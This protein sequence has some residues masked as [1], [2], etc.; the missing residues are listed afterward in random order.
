MVLEFETDDVNEQIVIVQGQVVKQILDTEEVLQLPASSSFPVVIEQVQGLRGEKGEIG[1][2]N[3]LTI[4]SVTASAPG[5]P[6]EATITGESPS[7]T[8]NFVI[9][10]GNTGPATSLSVAAVNTLYSG[11]NPTVEVGGT[12]PT[13]TLT[14]GIPKGAEILSGTDAPATE[15]GSINDWYINT[16]TWDMY[17]KTGAAVWT[18][19]MNIRGATGPANNLTIGTVTSA[20]SNVTPAVTVTGTSPN[21]ALNFTIPKGAQI[22]QGTDTPANG[23]GSVGDWFINT[24]NWDVFEKT[25]AAVWTNRGNIKG[26]TG[27][28]GATGPTG[29]ANQLSIGTVTTGAPGSTA[30]ANITGTA[31]VQTLSL[32]IPRGDVGATGPAPNLA[33]GTVTTGA[34]GSS[35]A[36]TVTGTNP[37]YLI[38]LTVPR[39]D[40]GEIG[41]QWYSGANAPTSGQYAVGDYY[42]V[43]GIS[44]TGDVYKKTDATTWTLEGNIRGLPG[45]GNVNS[46]NGILPDGNGQIL[47][48]SHVIRPAG[49]SDSGNDTTTGYW[50]RIATITLDAQYQD[51][52]I[53]VSINSSETGAD[54]NQGGFVAMNVRQ[55]DPLGTAPAVRFDTYE[56]RDMTPADL[57]YTVDST[58][59]ESAVTFWIKSNRPYTKFTYFM[60][61]QSNSVGLEALDFNQG[62]PRVA[63]EPVG[64]TANGV[65]NWHVFQ[66]EQL[67]A[68]AIND[69]FVVN[70][71]AEMLALTAQVGDTAVRQDT[72]TTYILK[73]EPATVL[74]NWIPLV[75]NA[76]NLTQGTVPDAVLPGRLQEQPLLITD[77][78]EAEESGFYQ[79]YSTAANTPD[80]ATYIGYS[81]PHGGNYTTQTVWRASN[82][83]IV[84]QRI[85]LSGVWGAWYRLQWSQASQDAR[86]VQLTGNQTIAGTKT[87]SNYIIAGN[88]N[89]TPVGMGTVGAFTPQMGVATTNPV[90]SIG[91]TT[92]DGTR[93]RRLAVMLN[94]TDGTFGLSATYATGGAMDFVVQHA[95]TEILRISPTGNATIPGTIAAANPTATNHLTTK[96]Y[97]DAG[98]SG[99]ANTAHNHDAS[100]IN[101]GTLAIARIPTGTTSTTVALG[102]HLHAGVYEPVIA[103]GTTAQYRRGDNTWQTLNSAA[104]GLG[105]VPN[106]TGDKMRQEV[107]GSS[108]TNGWVRIATQQN[109]KGIATFTVWDDTSSI[110]NYV[111]FN[112]SVSYNEDPQ[113]TVLNSGS[114]GAASITGIRIARDLTTAGPVFSNP[115]ILEVQITGITAISVAMTN[116]TGS[117]PWTLVTPANVSLGANYTTFTTIPLNGTSVLATTGV[118]NAHGRLRA[119]W[120]QTVLN[121]PLTTS[122]AEFELSS[123]SMVAIGESS[124]GNA[125]PHITLYRTASGNRSGRGFRMLLDG[126]T[127]PFRWQA[128]GPDVVYGTTGYADLAT[129][130]VSGNLTTVGTLT[131]GGAGFYGAGTNITGVVHTSGNENV[132][133]TKTFTGQLWVNSNVYNS[134]GQYFL[135][136]PT[137]PGGWARGLFYQNS[138]D[139]HIAA[140]GAYGTTG[141]ETLYISHGSAP[142]TNSDFEISTTG[143]TMRKPL[144]NTGSITAGGAGF[145]GSGTNITNVVHTSGDE[146]IGGSKTF[147]SAI[148][149][150]NGLSGDAIRIGN[151]AFLVDINEANAIGI[152]GVPTR[153][154]AVIRLGSGNTT[155]ISGDGTTLTL[156][157]G[158][159]SLSGQ[160][161]LTN[162]T[163]NLINFANFG[164]APPSVT[165]RSSGT[166]ILL[167]N[168]LT[169]SSVDYAFGIN[170]STLW[171]SIPTS[172]D[173]FRWYGGTSNIMTLTGQGALSTSGALTV[174]AANATG[175]FTVSSTPQTNVAAIGHINNGSWQGPGIYFGAY[176]GSTTSWSNVQSGGI[177]YWGENVAGAGTGATKMTLSG[178]ASPT[179]TVQS[180][181]VVAAAATT[182][183]TTNSLNLQRFEFTVA[184]AARPTG[185]KY[186]EW[187]GPV[188]PTNAIDGDTWVNTSA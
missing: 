118:I 96:S 12:A 57:K 120:T 22:L 82:A 3:V 128:T 30:T 36:A 124:S 26:A 176:V 33:V 127:G 52:A 28:T 53:K 172:T 45:S 137:A 24:T 87:F 116:N 140:F 80:A 122:A 119:G 50:S 74:A 113:I 72:S 56:L 71:E 5:A 60:V 145:S 44:G 6:A 115:V 160:L 126:S 152:Q 132:S 69:T 16:T 39:G 21:Q 121:T 89:L 138:S 139:T 91:L 150:A 90:T 83:E 20:A 108:L 123:N 49:V 18:L 2:G 58:A 169:G 59:T 55:N 168:G 141:L 35:A 8:L 130:D 165:T 109:G 154:A 171:S 67:P 7:Q 147:S 157:G 54:P 9:P 25:A 135:Y 161:N 185:S 177:L 156:I 32:T 179:L 65:A 1:E 14:F 173:F 166:K 111:E 175:G 149:T 102:N 159:V 77:W 68:I 98:L 79:A 88:S 170:S 183:A 61:D 31:P 37:N 17:K 151:D 66:K 94:D 4:G 51:F 19:Q 70:S 180:G 76:S 182:T 133:G 103:A 27:Q 184:S 155:G 144:T 143:I 174:A 106:Y 34:A 41:A 167:W 131:A 158:M 107:T 99:K 86:Y 42:L 129:L 114:Y 29:P 10:R 81:V 110:H 178:G 188:E 47:L 125:H 64:A 112:V 162:G 97:V 142:W 43:T 163:S 187:V 92:A 100:A 104:V 134:G 148:I 23:T 181:T 146:T 117:H 101:A 38:N 78:N 136:Q 15:A 73:T 186:V 62:E 84:W 105:N 63:T 48:N 164:V 40:K 93:N 11:Q 75:F 85:K 13:Q 95:T 153:T 46:V